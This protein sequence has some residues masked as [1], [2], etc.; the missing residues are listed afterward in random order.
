MT[1]YSNFLSLTMFDSFLYTRWGFLD[2]WKTYYIFTTS[3]RS[4]YRQTLELSILNIQDSIIISS[5][6]N[7]FIHWYG[8]LKALTCKNQQLDWT[9][10]CVRRPCPQ[11]TRSSS[12]TYLILLHLQ[13]F[14]LN[15]SASLLWAQSMLVPLRHLSRFCTAILPLCLLIHYD[16]SLYNHP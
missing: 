2:V 14:L 12:P 10:W 13:C 15:N 1:F 3:L 9:I 16:T 7:F 5:H 11:T 4:R 6:L 8:V